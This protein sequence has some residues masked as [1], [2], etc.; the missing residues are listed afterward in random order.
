MEKNEIVEFLNGANY[1]YFKNSRQKLKEK[2][3][4]YKGGKCEIC[5]YD[6]C[7]AALD[8]HH[9]NPEEKE[10]GITNG[11]VIPFELAKKEADKC[12][13]VCSNCHREIHY[14]LCLE[15]QKQEKEKEIKIYTEIM[16]NRDKYPAYRFKDSYKILKNTN[17][18]NDIKEGKPRK[19]ILEKYHVNN[20]T[21]NKFLHENGIEYS[22]KK[23]VEN[24]P[25]KEELLK[26]LENNSK[27]SIGRMFGV[28]CNAVIKWC[29][30]F[31]I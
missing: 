27:S 28:S 29:K 2:L 19:E 16:N 23:K 4:N 5:G 11:K 30:K 20:K 7:I 24:K 22:N 1:R 9:L 12:I 13:L 17:I 3:V 21:F 15:K 10:F 31:N 25:T 8:F 18:I 26:L 6:K 14:N